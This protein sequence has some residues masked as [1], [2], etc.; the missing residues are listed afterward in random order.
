MGENMKTDKN[1]IYK[2][3]LIK[4][5]LHIK[6]GKPRAVYLT[7]GTKISIQYD[8]NGGSWLKIDRTPEYGTE[9]LI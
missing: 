7:D 3:K 4:S 5:I 9:G 2:S 6:T 8:T 1:I